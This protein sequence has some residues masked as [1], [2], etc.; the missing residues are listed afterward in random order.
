MIGHWSITMF[1]GLS[2]VI[3]IVWHYFIRHYK[4][5]HYKLNLYCIQLRARPL[6]YL[7]GR[8]EEMSHVKEFL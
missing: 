7:D 2:M 4:L 6:H 8:T 3:I 1:T 5:F